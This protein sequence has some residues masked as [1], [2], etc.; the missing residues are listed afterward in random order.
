MASQVHHI[1][2]I[3]RDLDA[4]IATYENILNMPVTARDELEARGI[5]SAR[6]Q[7][8]PTWLVLV[9]PV[10]SGTIPARFLEEHGEGFFL[11]SLQ[12]DSLEMQ[13]ER[14]GEAMFSSEERRGI[15]DWHVRDLD[16]AQTFGAQL[17]LTSIN[18]YTG[19]SMPAG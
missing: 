10:K 5:I 4:A 2:F 1:N 14:L 12:V 11:M 8:G 7:L 9:Q 17:Q 6:F 16:A 13:S 18:D 3:V 19:K 15:E